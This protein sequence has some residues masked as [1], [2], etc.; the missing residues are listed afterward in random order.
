MAELG[1]WIIIL[2]PKA[3]SLFVVTETTPRV[4]SGKE[5]GGI[6]IPNKKQWC[7]P[8]HIN[9]KECIS[10]LD[11]KLWIC[12]FYIYY[13]ISVFLS[14]S[15]KRAQVS[16]CMENSFRPAAHTFEPLAL[17]ACICVIIC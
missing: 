4:V 7:K 1:Y 15:F 10:Y 5:A 6:S 17:C 14:V 11:I 16:D 13:Y 3:T 2:P 9:I 8:A 12:F